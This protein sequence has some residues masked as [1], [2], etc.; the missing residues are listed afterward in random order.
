MSILV[1][2]LIL[3]VRSQTDEANDDDVTDPQIIRA[4]NRA[5]RHASNILARK[6]EEIMWDSTTVTTTGGTREY[7]IPTASFGSRI[8][9]IEVA[10]DDSS[11]VRYKL[12]RLSNHKT[13][14]FI[15][16]SQ[17]DIPTHYSIKRNK[18]EVY[19]TP[20]SNLTLHVHYFK[21][22]EDFVKQQGRVETIDTSNNYITVDSIG[23]DVS[24]STDGFGAYINIIDY[25]TGNIKRTLQVSALDSTSG[26][27][28]FKSSGL[29]RST[30]LGHTVSTSIGSDVA[31]DDYVC[32]VTGT[33]VPEIDEA[34]TDYIIQHAVVAI[35][36]RLGEPTNE[37][38][39]ELKELETE[40][41]KSWVSREQ[42]RRVRKG[43]K[44]WVSA[45]GISH[46]RLLI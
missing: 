33:C 2:D 34:Y 41:L 17:T 25:R 15:T 30:V 38:F 5:Q 23:S 14:N 22:A 27:I 32:L 42:S 40:L 11:N 45:T 36:R 37:D 1:D 19:P 35:R 39:A 12:Q 44:S 46:R 43:S 8:E 26:Q 16:S 13:T 10:T 9:K 31:V 29:T 3:Q 20:K 6:F 4:L 24:T 21:R 18:F 28:T 7:D